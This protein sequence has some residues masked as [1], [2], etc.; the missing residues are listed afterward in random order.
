MGLLEEAF[1]HPF[2]DEVA[3][4]NARDFIGFQNAQAAN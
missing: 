3:K 4:E 1:V 2:A